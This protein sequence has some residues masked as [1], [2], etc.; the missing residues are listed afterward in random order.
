MGQCLGIGRGHSLHNYYIHIIIIHHH[1]LAMK[2][3]LY[4]QLQVQA[5][6]TG[7]NRE[8]A[9]TRS[10][11]VANPATV[12]PSGRRVQLPQ[13]CATCSACITS[14]RA[15]LTA[16]VSCDARSAA[17]SSRLELTSEQLRQRSSSSAT[18][19]Q[20]SRLKHFQGPVA[21]YKSPLHLR[22]SPPPWSLQPSHRTH[23]VQAAYSHITIT[24]Y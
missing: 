24:C 18:G 20:H 13:C 15:S 22:V 8:S 9:S 16:T 14:A 6:G 19:T 4:Q 11:H 17:Q 23:A 5:G 10:V 12:A 21:S 3:D 1:C 2:V 7:R